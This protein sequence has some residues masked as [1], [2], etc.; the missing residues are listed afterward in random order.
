M[1]KK[2]FKVL[3]IV[4]F[5][6]VSVAWAEG[7]SR[8][9]EP[10]MLEKLYPTPEGLDLNDIVLGD[11]THNGSGCR[12]ST[13]EATMT[14]DKKKI[15]VLFSNYAARVDEDED[16]DDKDCNLAIPVVVPPGI[17]V[18]IIGIAWRGSVRTK[19]GGE[20]ELY[21]EYFFSG[22]QGPRKL[23]WWSD[24][25]RERFILEDKIPFAE[26]LWSDCDGEEYVARVDTEILA[27]GE[28]S[29][30]KI[31]SADITGSLIFY[32][33]FRSCEIGSDSDSD[34]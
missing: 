15:A 24:G 23:D 6:V 27:E 9:F 5:A 28:G 17:S 21:R 7:K 19:S 25:D 18:G 34:E 22:K 12:P 13:V 14:A 2:F 11:L 10:D 20:V 1:V 16:Y 3:V 26:M 30:I 33:A 8:Y 32:L 29:R 31:R 4:S